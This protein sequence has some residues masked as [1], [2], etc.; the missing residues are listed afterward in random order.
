MPPPPRF[1]PYYRWLEETLRED[2]EQG[3][4]RPGDALPTEHQL[5]RDYNLSITTVRRAVHDLVRAGWIYRQAGKGTFVKRNK[6]EERLA[7]LTSFAEEMQSRNITPQ[8]KLVSATP[9]VPPAEITR[10]L[11][12][13]PRQEAYLIQR[14]QLANDDPIALARGYWIPEI[15]EQLAQSDLDHISLYEMVERHLHIPLVEADES[16]SAAVA[17]ADIARK[18]EIPRHA[19]L[20]VRRRLTYTTEMRPIE[21][22]TTFYRADQYEYKIRLAR[23]GV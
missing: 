19:P 10:A 6:L 13:S 21:F 23:Q 9:S 12:L 2:I 22:T 20:L 18:L 3:V 4:Y 15:G 7:R 16:I 14:V 17:S 5:M 1:S 11:K 8:F